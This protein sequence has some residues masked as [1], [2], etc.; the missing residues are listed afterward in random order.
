V[1][2]TTQPAPAAP[3]PPAAPAATESPITGDTTRLR[4]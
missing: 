2:I 1:P 4:G 3:Q